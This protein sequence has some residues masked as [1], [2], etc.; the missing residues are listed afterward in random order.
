[1]KNFFDFITQAGKLKG[2][3]RRGW[4]MHNIK[5]SETTAEH[6]FHLALLVWVLGEKKKNI[7]V[8]KAIKMALAHDLCEVY[9]KDFTPY[10]PL[11]PDDPKEAKKILKEWPKFTPELK[12]KK[13]KDKYQMELD[14]LEKLISTLPRKTAEELKSV[15]L[16]YEKKS[17]PEARFVKQADKMINFLQ[18]IEYWKKQ[19]KIQH[20]LWVRWIKEIIDDPILLDFLKEI[21]D[22]WIAKK[23][24]N[25][26]S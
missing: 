10:D 17:S 24:G 13:E 3:E 16:E 14:G 1:M 11:L 9:A 19:G 25:N 15:W 12:K 4:V 21:E 26:N 22:N 18:G 5:K 23:N 20:K 2:K 8:N 7:N 6:I